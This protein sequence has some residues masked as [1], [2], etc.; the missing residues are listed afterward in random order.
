[1]EKVSNHSLRQLQSFK[2]RHDGSLSS[3]TSGLCIRRMACQ[4]GGTLLGH[5]YDLGDCRDDM[6][7]KV[8]VEKA[9]ANSMTHLRDLGY[10]AHAISLELCHLCG[11]Y[12]LQNMCLG[13]ADCGGSFQAKPG[14]TKLASQYV[15]EEAITGHSEYN[16]D[17]GGAD[18]QAEVMGIDMSGIGAT[19]H[20]SGLCGS[21]ATDAPLISS[22]FY[23]LRSDATDK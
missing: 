3:A 5:M 9:Q 18:D 22:F 11:P 2:L 7:L 23:L 21:F 1:M 6:N 17:A 14:W 19:K 8:K 13:K 15:G 10:P 12:R 16:V 20:K 4:E